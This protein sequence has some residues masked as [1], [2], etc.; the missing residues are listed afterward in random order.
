VAGGEVARRERDDSYR[1]HALLVRTLAGTQIARIIAF[2][3]T[4]RFASFGLPRERG[5]RA[6]PSRA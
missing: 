1:A 5:A 2:Q 3:D 4:G 6:G